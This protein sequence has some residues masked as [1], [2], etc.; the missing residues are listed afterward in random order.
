MHTQPCSSTRGESCAMWTHPT[1]ASSSLKSLWIC[2]LKTT[3][4][5]TRSE[6]ELDRLR[7]SIRASGWKVE[8]SINFV[9]HYPSLWEGRKGVWM[10]ESDY[11]CRKWVN[12]QWHHGWL[13]ECGVREERLYLFSLRRWIPEY[14]SRK[15]ISPNKVLIV[16]NAARPHVIII[17]NRP[18]QLVNEHVGILTCSHQH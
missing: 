8:K 12:K 10:E 1:F 5:T 15:V 7:P 4:H 14:H 18:E 17:S 13:V 3:R 11:F 6:E 2:P 16:P 9:K